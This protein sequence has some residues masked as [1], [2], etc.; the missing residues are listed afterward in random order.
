M[1]VAAK[2]NFLIQYFVSVSRKSFS[3]GLGQ[4]LPSRRLPANVWSQG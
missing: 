4:N 2:A 1:I 3:D